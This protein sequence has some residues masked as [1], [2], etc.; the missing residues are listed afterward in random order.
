MKLGK[1]M[2]KMVALQLQRALDEMDYLNPFQSGLG[3]VMEQK[4]HWSHL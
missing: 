4:Q 2:G 1:V 3:P